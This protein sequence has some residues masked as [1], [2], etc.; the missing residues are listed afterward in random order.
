MD[1]GKKNRERGTLR[2]AGLNEIV[3]FGV[4]LGL[5]IYIYYR[6]LSPTVNFIDSGEL[7]SV[8][9]SLGIA[10]PTGYP[11]YTLWGRLFTLLGG[12]NPAVSMNFMSALFGSAAALL[13][14]VVVYLIVG[15][16]KCGPDRISRGIRCYISLAAGLLFAFSRTMWQVSVET[17][18]YS[19]ATLFFMLLIL[20]ALPLM[21]PALNGRQKENSRAF[22]ALPLFGYV[23][24]LAMGNHMSIV[25]ILPVVLYLFYL[26]KLWEG[27][28]WQ[29]L[30]CFACFFFLGLSVYL[31][32]PIRSMENP[33]LNWGTP[34]TLEF[35]TRHVTA[36]QYRVWMF[37]GDMDELLTSIGNYFRLLAEQF[38]P[39]LLFLV[40]PGGIL[41]F[42]R[43][44]SFM[45]ALVILFLSDVV[46]SLNYSIPDINPYF[47]PSFVVVVLFIGAG[48]YQV[49]EGFYRW[50]PKLVILAAA[51]GF[52]LPL[53][54][55]RTNY[56]DCD[57][58]RDYMAYELASNLL[59]TVSDGAIVLT[60]TWDLYAPVMYLQLVEGKRNDV[61]MIDYELMR[62]SWYVREKAMANPEIFLAAGREVR[63]FLDLVAVFEE[64]GPFDSGKLDNAFYDMLNAILLSRYPGSPSYIDF[65]D[66]PALAPTLKKDPQGVIFQLREEFGE[67]SFD[68]EGYQLTSTLDPSIYR[69]E[70]ALWLRSL[71]PMYAIRKAIVLRDMNNHTEA[72]KSLENALVFDRNSLPVLN[73]L[74][75]SYFRMNLLE[76]ARGYYRRMSMLAPRNTGVRKKLQELQ[77]L[78]RGD[79]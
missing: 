56:S 42:R 77:M 74:G 52:V 3:C 40:L 9:H 20:I 62:R 16:G 30:L 78:M 47:I 70:R 27:R 46:Y 39:A 35:L 12:S 11:I 51:A 36:W 38:H 71:Y 72:I 37:S 28:R 15:K 44:R 5:P 31:Y 57:R 60:R 29:S 25:L 24:G 66:N 43:M 14:G 65:D 48:L 10:H 45:F 64:G 2:S 55:L 18:V 22:I 79:K 33:L 13:L 26:G 53:T 34:H 1:E 4:L 23:W 21:R 63:T 58:S 68:M 41:L 6:T 19:L 8:S 54:A 69:D 59:S 49:V 32:L 67:E 7:I 76:K 75:D 61:T 73:L 17:E 50:K